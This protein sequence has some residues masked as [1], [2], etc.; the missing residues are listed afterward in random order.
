MC[1]ID[2]I[3]VSHRLLCLSRLAK[4]LIPIVCVVLA[5]CS[6]PPPNGPESESSDFSPSWSPTGDSIA[7]VHLALSLNDPFPDGVYVVGAAGGPRRLIQ[8][9]F[10]R[11]VDWSPDGRR[12][13]FDT[14]SGLFSCTSHGESLQTIYNGVAYFPS[15]SPQGNLVAFDDITHIWVVPVGGGTPTAIT[16]SLG[17]GR[18][19]DWS[20]DGQALI[21]RFG[22]PGAQG[23]ELAT[24]S[25]SG[26]LL[27]RVTNNSH[28]ERSPAWSPIG[29]AVAWNPW[30]RGPQGRVHPEFRLTD[31]SGTASRLLVTGEGQIGW[32]PDGT[33]LVLSRQTSSGSKL[34]TITTTGQNLTQITF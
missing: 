6:N 31:T 21:I 34:F 23:G 13:V 8:Q 12:L 17:G 11:S 30:P 14:P 7:F 16:D 2:N 25:L 28:E 1:L 24:V 3:A 32:S 20:P 5:S 26:Q 22:F 4:G 10:A 18:D 29:S 19:P 33:R 15:W 27:G 9:T